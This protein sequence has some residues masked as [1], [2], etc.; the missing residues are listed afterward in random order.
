MRSAISNGINWARN[1]LFD[2]LWKIGTPEAFDEMIGVAEAGAEIGDGNCMMRLGRAYRDGKGVSK[3]LSKAISEFEKAYE[4]KI[5]GSWE[6]L[7]YCGFKS[8]NKTLHKKI[9]SIIEN[10]A[11]TGDSSNQILLVR[12]LWNGIMVSKDRKK[13]IWWTKHSNAF[14]YAFPLKPQIIIKTQ[15][16]ES[17]SIALVYSS[18]KNDFE[19]LFATSIQ[20]NLII[21]SIIDLDNVNS[22]ID[23]SNVINDSYVIFTSLESYDAVKSN[24]PSNTIFLNVPSGDNSAYCNSTDNGKT[25]VIDYTNINELRSKILQKQLPKNNV[26]VDYYD[27][28][29][30]GLVL[31]NDLTIKSISE[32]IFAIVAGQTVYNQ[33][34]QPNKQYIISSRAGMGDDY[35]QLT[36]T[37]SFE[38]YNNISN[39]VVILPEKSKELG[40]IFGYPHIVLSNDEVMQLRVFAS[41]MRN[42]DSP[43]F[44]VGKWDYQITG[45]PPT[46]SR[47]AI[48]GKYIGYIDY[49]GNELSLPPGTK[50]DP[51]AIPITKDPEYERSILI[52]PYARFLYG[53]IPTCKDSFIKIMQS[54]ADILSNNGY[55]VYTNAIEEHHAIL[56]NTLPFSKS[57]YD[58][59]KLASSFDY[60][61]S[62]RTGF[63]D[64]LLHTK[65]NMIVLTPNG[66]DSMIR[67]AEVNECPFKE[68]WW[69]GNNDESIIKEIITT[70][71]G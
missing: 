65:C 59:I 35:K 25:T 3:N 40:T 24:Y 66:F 5:P 51:I 33:Y 48:P 54:V 71:I 46:L 23:Y 4:Y 16:L 53:A 50:Y 62:V 70:I 21:D 64:A 47:P 19:T 10:N 37:H 32:I 45:A 26:I 9:I 13:A 61:I 67:A 18:S 30:H 58:S 56:N 57:M 8:R 38:K 69:D 31:F 17:D 15:L 63:A 6:E 36:R 1:E 7:L 43:L 41:F 28:N 29:Q 60:I 34:I 39:V 68:I 27:I 42:Y 49:I 12:L 52:N 20:N 22:F 44:M 11:K 14:R 55:H 2:I